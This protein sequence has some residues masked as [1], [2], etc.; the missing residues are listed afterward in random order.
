MKETGESKMNTPNL[1]EGELMERQRECSGVRE[2]VVDGKRQVFNQTE[3]A[4]GPKT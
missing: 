1:Q 2:K 4:K 3:R